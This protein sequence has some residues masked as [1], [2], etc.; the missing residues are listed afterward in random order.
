LNFSG[1]NKKYIDFFLPK[2]WKEN[3][4]GIQ[5]MATRSR[6]AALNIPCQWRRTARFFLSF[7]IK[8]KV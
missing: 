8:D 3:R 7:K 4:D 6:K 5:E 2:D 1:R